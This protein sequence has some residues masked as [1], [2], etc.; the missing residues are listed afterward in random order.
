MNKKAILLINVGTPDKPEIKE[1]RKFLREFL[2]DRMVIDLPWIL[3]KILVNL[4]IIPFRVKKST[5][6]YKSLWTPEGSPL[7]VYLIKLSRQLQLKLKDNYEVYPAMRYGKPSLKEVLSQMKEVKYKEI[8]ILPLYPQYA[9]STSG[10]VKSKVYE[11][12]KRWK[13]IPAIRFIEQ[14]YQHEAFI[15]A[16]SNQISKYKPLEYE[17]VVFSYHG[18]P[19]RHIRKIHSSISCE[20]CICEKEMPD[21]GSFCYKAACYETTRLLVKSLKIPDSKFSVGFQSRLS[22]NWLTPFTDEIIAKLAQNGIK[23]ILITAPSFVADCL[24]TIVEL[25]KEYNELFQKKGGMELTLVKSLND[26]DEWVDAIIK[27]ERIIHH[28]AGYPL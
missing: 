6:L 23:R 28:P 13:E 5:A 2:N 19:L 16:F 8:V 22:K 21:Y 26:S 24:E 27:I 4:I 25:E 15:H 12:I 3:Q 9:L 10:S 11:I 1:V 7:L 20:A 18:L 17:H 14:F